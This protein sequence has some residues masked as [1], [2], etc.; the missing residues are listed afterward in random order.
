MAPM[1]SVILTERNPALVV[2]LCADEIIRAAIAFWSTMLPVTTIVAEDGYRVTEIL[3]R[4]ECRLLITDRALPPWPGLEAFWQLRTRYPALRIA[5]I[6]RSSQSEA[7]LA[8]LAGVTD[9][10]AHPLQQQAVFETIDAAT[11]G[12]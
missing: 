7:S 5:F 6:E 3:R 2:V 11:L 10:L 9:I 12:R 8:R 4:Q 1:D